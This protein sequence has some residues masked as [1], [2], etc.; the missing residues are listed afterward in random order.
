MAWFKW[1]TTCTWICWRATCQFDVAKT[2]IENDWH[3]TIYWCKV[4][5]IWYHD[6]VRLS[7][8]SL[9]IALDDLSTGVLL[10]YAFCSS[11][12]IFRTDDQADD[13]IST[14]HILFQQHALGSSFS[15]EPITYHCVVAN[16]HTCEADVL[17]PL[18]D[19]VAILV[20]APRTSQWYIWSQDTEVGT[21][22]S[23][24]PHDVEE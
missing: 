24:P 16:P 15:H 12:V 17:H 21:K 1:T 6:E 19:A 8:S 20:I 23:L 10:H 11:N 4:E 3:G 22:H 2:S 14:P 18:P 7:Y 9:N 13:D 5:M